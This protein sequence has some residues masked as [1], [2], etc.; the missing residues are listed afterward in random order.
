MDLELKDK[1]AVVTGAAGAIGGAIAEALAAEGAHV[2]IWDICDEAGSRRAETLR[3]AGGQAISCVCDVTDRDAVEAA[4]AQTLDAF[5]TVDLLVNAAGGSRAQT[6][7]S[8]DLSFF[9]IRQRDME[10]VMALNYLSAVLPSQAVGPT[11]AQKGEGAIVNIGSVAGGEPLTR[12]LT[13]SNA[14]AAVA[15]FT[16]WLAVHMAQEYSPR[17]RV[18]AVA[19]GFVLTDQNRF[20]LL[21]EQ[22]GELTPRGETVLSQVPMRRFGE[23]HEI[24][25]LAL[26]LASPRASFL[27]GTVIPVD[28]GFTAFC[29]V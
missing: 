24:A 29:G 22:S 3:G 19:P 8:P 21:D 20:L 1:V 28:G 10:L 9:E 26:W 7:T 13:Y 5:S 4:L 18:N 17:I 27:T 14:K 15:S 11:L 25:T 23:P 6:T 16:Q 2:A 12:S